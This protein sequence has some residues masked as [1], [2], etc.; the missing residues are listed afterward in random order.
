VWSTSSRACS[1]ASSSGRA[2]TMARVMPAW[3]AGGP[4]RPHSTALTISST[5]FLASPKTIIVLSM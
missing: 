1:A 3:Y 4:R 2:L 5:T